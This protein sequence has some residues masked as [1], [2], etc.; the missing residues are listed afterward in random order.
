MADIRITPVD[1]TFADAS[2]WPAENSAFR[3]ELQKNLGEHRVEMVA[4]SWPGW[5]GS[6]LN[7]GHRYRRAAGER[8]AE[9]LR[10]S[11]SGN[12]HHFVIT[13]SHGG[14]VARYALRDAVL[15]ES[16]VVWFTWA[17]LF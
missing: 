17:P 5:L 2:D 8:L 16:S 10:A 9:F 12:A 4:F 14:N 15:K 11:T 1:G 7:N 3:R 13:H 6:R